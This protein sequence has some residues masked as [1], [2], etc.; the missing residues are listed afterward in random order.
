VAD[1][2]EALATQYGLDALQIAAL[3]RFLGLLAEDDHAPTS[4]RDPVT[5][6][7]VHV[8]DSL[9][10]LPALDD[11]LSRGAPGLVADVG[12]GA[13]VPGI[14]LAVARPGLRFDLIE[15]TSRKC[16]FLS[17]VLAQIGLENARVRCARA[18]ELAHA[19]ARETYGV[20]LARAVA[21]LA[22]LVEYAAPMLGKGGRLI[23]WKGRPEPGEESGGAVAAAQIG[24]APL[25]SQPV[26]P[27]AGSRNR[28]L[29]LYQK[30]SPCPS[31]FPRRPGVALKKPLG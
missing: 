23:A 3:E 4:V 16:A 31:G 26:T 28:A 24:L 17:R 27:Y 1:R 8:A 2:L 19:D 7:D 21:P 22:T 10:A 14:P 29:Y 18:E 11:A 6:V 15:A 13:G 20:V 12:T 9:T 30:V 25:P 5:A